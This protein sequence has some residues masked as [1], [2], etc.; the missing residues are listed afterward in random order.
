MHIYICIYI[1]IPTDYREYIGYGMDGGLE[2]NIND[3]IDS[4]ITKFIKKHQHLSFPKKKYL[5]EI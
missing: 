1:Y 2:W 5:F 4:K 3:Y